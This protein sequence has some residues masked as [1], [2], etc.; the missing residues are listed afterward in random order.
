MGLLLCLARGVFWGLLC[1]CF[2]GMKN[3]MMKVKNVTLFSIRKENE[4]KKK[5]DEGNG[6]ENERNFWV[7]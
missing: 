3:W 4:R 2:G 5:L 6:K 1:L 7:V